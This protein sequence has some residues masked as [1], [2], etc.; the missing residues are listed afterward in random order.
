MAGNSCTVDQLIRDTEKNALNDAIIHLVNLKKKSLTDTTDVLNEADKLTLDGLNNLDI[1]KT[2]SKV[3]NAPRKTPKL[4]PKLRMGKLSVDQ[5]RVL[6]SRAQ[7]PV[8]LVLCQDKFDP[9]SFQYIMNFE[10][11]SPE[12]LVK[13]LVINGAVPSELTDADPSLIRPD[14]TVLPLLYDETTY[15]PKNIRLTRDRTVEGVLTRERYHW[16]NYPNSSPVTKSVNEETSN[17]KNLPQPDENWQTWKPV[18][19]Y[20]HSSVA[21]MPR[22]FDATIIKNNNETIN[23]VATVY[24]FDSLCVKLRLN[25]ASR[26]TKFK[27]VIRKFAPSYAFALLNADLNT[28]YSMMLRF[29]D[30]VTDKERLTQ[31]LLRFT[32]VAGQPLTASI[33]KVYELYRQI[34]Y[35][36][37]AKVSLDPT[38]PDYNPDCVEFV[39]NALITLTD[40]EV[41][42]QVMTVV[43]RQVSN[44]TKHDPLELIKASARVEASEG[45]PTVLLKL[46][47]PGSS[48]ATISWPAKT[49]NELKDLKKLNHLA[50][51]NNLAEEEDEWQQFIT[52]KRAKNKMLESQ[53]VL[54]E[55]NKVPELSA[56]NQTIPV[57]REGSEPCPPGKTPPASGQGNLISVTGLMKALN[58]HMTSTPKKGDTTTPALNIS[59]GSEASSYADKTFGS[60]IR[61]SS[62]V[63]APAPSTSN[64][65]SL[66][67]TPNKVAGNPSNEID[68]PTR[69]TRSTAL[70]VTTLMDSWS[71]ALGIIE[72]MKKTP[73][74][75]FLFTHTNVSVSEEAVKSHALTFDGTTEFYNLGADIFSIIGFPAAPM[76]YDQNEARAMLQALKLLPA[77]VFFK[78][79]FFNCKSLAPIFSNCLS[80]INQACKEAATGYLSLNAV[81]TTPVSIAAPPSQSKDSTSPYR[82]TQ[83]Q[84]FSRQRSEEKFRN[85]NSNR[86]ER[87]R[88]NRNRSFSRNRNYSRNGSR[89]SRSYND[90]GSYNDQ[91]RNRSNSYQGS[92]DNKSEDNRKS[93]SYR[94]N[95]RSR[96]D[97]ESKRSSST[98]DPSP[99]RN[100][101]PRKLEIRVMNYRDQKCYPL[102]C[103]PSNCNP[104]ECKKCK[105]GHASHNCA[106]YLYHSKTPCPNC[107]VLFHSKEECQLQAVIFPDASKNSKNV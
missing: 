101:A 27:E 43:K 2:P 102:V 98:S 34:K 91:G 72:Q 86:D 48:L 60:E 16:D 87:P 71:Q 78:T 15:T 25:E 3:E 37:D 44:G 107:K 50:L 84:N 70:N 85:N 90:K 10:E 104:L 63:Q 30:C 14:L 23:W 57:D 9:E 93:N 11:V 35:P 1:L 79:V 81:A 33:L 19:L 20:C 103:D 39:I 40:T 29:E 49:F 80:V 75:H 100:S 58:D 73:R 62:N 21:F 66:P 67:L 77:P 31:E 94:N 83:D 96:A 22:Q 54:F 18:L 105:N 42:K 64:S 17:K 88:N 92:R 13:T 47:K 74:G 51:S 52:Q 38:N 89:E 45:I 65:E 32:R 82:S 12:T 53:Q 55:L 46:Y 99:H 36:K 56:G 6:A 5:V 59:V 68:I 97:Q 76:T 28:L 106:F 26:L 41:A 8:H 24:E 61:D 69:V 4:P 95:S 7:I